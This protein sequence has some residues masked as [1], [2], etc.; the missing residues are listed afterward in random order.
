V[1]AKSGVF[2]TGNGVLGWSIYTALEI[3]LRVWV[4]QQN[5]G[6]LLMP[7]VPSL[8]GENRGITRSDLMP[9]ILRYRAGQA[10]S[11]M[12]ES[13]NILLPS[14]MIWRVP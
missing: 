8:A 4:Y 5:G 3:G 14:D 12:M 11:R 2:W 7:R 6:G 10:K 1:N 9:Q 13:A